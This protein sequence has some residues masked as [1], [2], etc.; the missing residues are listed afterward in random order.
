MERELLKEIEIIEGSQKLLTRTL[1][2]ASEQIR[3]L[4]S[5]IYFMDRDLEDKGNVLKIDD[6]NLKLKQTA[7]NLSMYH[8]FTPLDPAYVRS[9]TRASRAENRAF[10]GT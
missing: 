10:S 6:H 7:L 5:T 1:E 2:Q 8:G 9:S 4:K 3:R